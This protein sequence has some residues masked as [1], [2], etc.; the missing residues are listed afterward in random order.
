[1]FFCRPVHHLDFL[2]TRT[3]ARPADLGLAQ[4]RSSRTDVGSPGK[5][6]ASAMRGGWPVGALGIVEDR[7]QSAG[8]RDIDAAAG[9]ALAQP[10]PLPVVCRPRQREQIVRSTDFV[11]RY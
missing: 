4:P 3:A 1:M 6:I 2:A 7:T 9:L 5:A 8:D 10:D 11:S